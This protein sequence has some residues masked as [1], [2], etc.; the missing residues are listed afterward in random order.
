[1]LVRVTSID[2]G[3]PPRVVELDRLL[4]GSTLRASNW[5][6]AETRVYTCHGSREP[7]ELHWNDTQIPG[8][9][10][11]G[12]YGAS[13]PPGVVERAAAELQAG[14]AVRLYVFN[15]DADLCWQDLVEPADPP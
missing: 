14:R 15:S 5:I 7:Y 1:M 8:E 2:R 12:D 6:H 11:L 10:P 3:G 9:Q 13:C 4:A